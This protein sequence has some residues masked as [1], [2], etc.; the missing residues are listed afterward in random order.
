[1]PYICTFHCQ[2][3]FFFTSA[4]FK[5]RPPHVWVS[6]RLWALPPCPGMELTSNKTCKHSTIIICALNE[7]WLMPENVSF[8]ICFVD[9]LYSSHDRMEAEV[10]YPICRVDRVTLQVFTSTA[11]GLL[12][13][14]TS[15]SIFLVTLLHISGW[16]LCIL[17]KMDIKFK[18]VI[19]CNK[20]TQSL[21]CFPNTPSK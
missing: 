5:T 1:M 11:W 10:I 17:P 8:F 19:G 13:P 6:V 20:T 3:V 15:C 14:A 21:L 9:L 4:W 12:R 16:P 18:N 7:A 2:R